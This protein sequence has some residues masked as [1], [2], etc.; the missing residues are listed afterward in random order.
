MITEKWS[1]RALDRVINRMKGNTRITYQV[2]DFARSL[3]KHNMWFEID[4]SK[5]ITTE[6]LGGDYTYGRDYEDWFHDYATKE[7]PFQCWDFTSECDD[8]RQIVWTV[9]N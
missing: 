9:D 6:Y 7:E 5:T 1:I 4:D 3:L 2:R 8:D